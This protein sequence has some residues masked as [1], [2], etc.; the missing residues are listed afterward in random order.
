LLFLPKKYKRNQYARIGKIAKIHVWLREN[1]GTK[2]NGVMRQTP[3][4]ISQSDKT[5]TA[6]KFSPV[7]IFFDNVKTAF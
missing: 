5:G 4:T 1:Q 2:K 3:K 6:F 7:I